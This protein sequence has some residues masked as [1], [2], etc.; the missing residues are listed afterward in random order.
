MNAFTG[1]L[2]FGLGAAVSALVVV[3]G[4]TLDWATWVWLP[5]AAVLGPGLAIV[6]RSMAVEPPASAPPPRPAASEPPQPSPQ[7]TRVTDVPLPTNMGDY[8]FRFSAVVSWV[9]EPHVPP[10]NV[11]L[12]TLATRNVLDRA[13]TRTREY[14]P[15]NYALATIELNA[16]LAERVAIANG[17]YVWASEVTLRLSDADARR[18]EEMAALR[19]DKALW[20][21]RRS[22][23]MLARDFVG[24]EVL[25]DPGTAVKWWFGRHLDQADAPKTAVRDIADLRRLTAAAHNKDTPVWD[26]GEPPAL[27]PAPLPPPLPVTPGPAPHV[28]PREQFDDAVNRLAGD[29]DPAVRDTLRR[30][31]DDVLRTYGLAEPAVTDAPE[32][33]RA[34]GAAGEDAEMRAEGT[35]QPDAASNGHHAPER[36]GE[37]N[38]AADALA[39]PTDEASPSDRHPTPP[40]R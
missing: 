18:L 27:P 6:L 19:K 17:H 22:R 40:A 21:L 32:H 23:E 4:L 31:L 14:S 16:H 15:E 24:R 3:L 35:E 9:R 26:S 20:E 7:H 36:H 33:E 10:L 29:L 12:G 34:V 37:H 25:S 13:V 8:Q 38:G 39:P 5:L 30:R 11:D 28:D 2:A 1:R